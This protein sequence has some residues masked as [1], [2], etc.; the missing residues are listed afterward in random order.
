MLVSR[1]F[2]SDFGCAFCW[3][4]ST[5]FDGG[6]LK[7]EKLV[8]SFYVFFSFSLSFYL[9]L[10]DSD[11]RFMAR[12]FICWFFLYIA[13]SLFLCFQIFHMFVI[14]HF[15]FL[16]SLV[17]YVCSSYSCLDRALYDMIRY[18]SRLVLFVC[19]ACVFVSVMIWCF[20]FLLRVNFCSLC[21]NDFGDQHA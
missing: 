16:F 15:R 3:I 6:F 17:F 7:R 21:Y 2:V 13:K 9:F 18:V 11:I 10:I 1:I 14:F 4:L 19:F 5:F 20:L 8:L 12:H